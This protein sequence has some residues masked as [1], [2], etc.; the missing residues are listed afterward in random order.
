M[1]FRSYASPPPPPVSMTP[2]EKMKQAITTGELSYA[3]PVQM[4]AETVRPNEG[5]QTAIR[6]IVEV[7]GDTPGP[8]AGMFGIVGADHQLKSG[9]RDL[10]RSTDGKSYRLDFLVAVETGT[11]ELRFAVADASGAVGAVAQ[12]IVVK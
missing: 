7:P 6:V 4:S 8:V 3:V 2:E 11:Y 10:V 9:Q 12:T 5:L 1:L